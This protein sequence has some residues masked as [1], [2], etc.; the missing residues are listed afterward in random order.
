M[1]ERVGQGV[2]SQEFAAAVRAEGERVIEKVERRQPPFSGEWAA[3][4]PDPAWTIPELPAGWDTIPA[5][6]WDRRKWAY[7]S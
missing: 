5:Q 6:L 3:W 1:A 7:L 2:Y 4:T